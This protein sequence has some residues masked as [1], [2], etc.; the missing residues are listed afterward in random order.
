MEREPG[1]ARRQSD[2]SELTRLLSQ[3][4]TQA[5][6]LQHE[7][8]DCERTA[9]SSPIPIPKPVPAPTPSTHTALPAGTPNPSISSIFGRL[10]AS[11]LLPSPSHSPA[12]GARPALPSVSLVQGSEPRQCPLHNHGVLQEP[13]ALSL[14]N[15]ARISGSPAARGD[16]PVMAYKDLPRR[17]D[18]GHDTKVNAETSS[19]HKPRAEAMTV[20][21]DS[22][23]QNALPHC[24][25]WGSDYSPFGSSPISV[26]RIVAPSDRHHDPTLHGRSC[27]NG[28][29]AQ[30]VCGPDVEL[31]ASASGLSGALFSL[32]EDLATG[33]TAMNANMLVFNEETPAGTHVGTLALAVG[34]SSLE[35]PLCGTPSPVPL[36]GPG[37]GQ[38]TCVPPI[39]HLP[40]VQLN[41]CGNLP[42]G[43][44]DFAC[45][46]VFQI[47]SSLLLHVH[48]S[49]SKCQVQVT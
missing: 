46:D 24:G 27:P 6:C 17:P 7:Q 42:C 31:A 39:I 2:V 12:P 37:V 18:S 11:G 25:P 40:H 41:C 22:S 48:Q 44:Y 10:S 35:P 34:A 38:G 3:C 16:R 26:P 29:I 5:G 28:T 19:S 15:E 13:S 8:D 32:D 45:P 23:I 43:G 36:S 49:I 21:Q 47:M 9:T 1:A 33:L 20:A 14:V 30:A 4:S